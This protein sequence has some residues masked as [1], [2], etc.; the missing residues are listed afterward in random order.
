[1]AFIV[2]FIMTF[3][4]YGYQLVRSHT[5]LGDGSDRSLAAV[6]ALVFAEVFAIVFCEGLY[7]N[8]ESLC[9]SVCEGRYY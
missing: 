1:M 5:R 3:V 8:A 6:V 4:W 9:G 2:T 7:E